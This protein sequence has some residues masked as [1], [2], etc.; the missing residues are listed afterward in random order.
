[1]LKSASSV[2]WEPLCED[3]AR[4]QVRS[5]GQRG[6]QHLYAA[7]DNEAD[8]SCWPNACQWAQERQGQVISRAQGFPPFDFW[9][10]AQPNLLFPPHPVLSSQGP[11]GKRSPSVLTPLLR[12]IAP[13][14]CL[15]GTHFLDRCVQPGNTYRRSI[16]KLDH[17]Y[18]AHV[19][20]VSPEDG[21][22]NP[23]KHSAHYHPATSGLRLAFYWTIP[24]TK[25][26]N[27]FL[28]S[29][30]NPSW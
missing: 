1:M 8:E 4:D 17:N 19:S 28:F 25:K 10:L 22:G 6:T 20:Q 27:S 11:P 9:P 29:L 24:F 5:R 14:C 2:M 15:W 26:R 16:S 13:Y 30:V 3:T 12:P 18:W 7:D 23:A 21:T